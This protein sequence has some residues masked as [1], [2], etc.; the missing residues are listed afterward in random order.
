MSI[1]APLVIAVQ[2][3]MRW[4]SG[5]FLLSHTWSL[6]GPYASLLKELQA[7][8][9]V[10]D[11]WKPEQRAVMCEDIWSAMSAWPRFKPL[12]DAVWVYERRVADAR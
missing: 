11:D 12:V 8:L 6:T 1:D 9:I 7:C 2:A 10:C 5:K 4:R 3:V